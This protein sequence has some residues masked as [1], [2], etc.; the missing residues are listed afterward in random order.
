MR[1]LNAS[2]ESGSSGHSHSHS[3]HHAPV[4]AVSSAL[5]N[6]SVTSE[7]LRQRKEK[8]EGVV[9][10]VEEKKGTEVSASLRLSAYLNL[11][12]DFS[13]R[14]P[15]TQVHQILTCLPPI[16]PQHHRRTGKS[17]SLERP[18]TSIY[19]LSASLRLWRHPFTQA[20]NL[21]RS[22]PL[23]L[24]VMR[25]LTRYEQTP[26]GRLLSQNRHSLC[27]P[28]SDCRL[29]DSHQVGIHEKTSHD[30]SI[31]HRY[32]SV[33]WYILGYLDR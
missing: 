25:S 9:N 29:L 16:S 17:H 13:K 14:N 31:Y 30:L 12:G 20:P 24:S 28:Y 11:F 8:S 21:V 27:S 22:R 2:D 3:H 4:E 33:C 18:R 19:E 32:R 5:D 7:G 1:V 15:P 10:A 26:S 23:R 6:K